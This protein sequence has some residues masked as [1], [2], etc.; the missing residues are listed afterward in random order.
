MIGILVG[1]PILGALSDKIGRKRA[2]LIS[3]IIFILAG[4]FVALAPNFTL[5]MIARFILGASSPGIY[6]TSF[7]LGMEYRTT[8]IQAFK[9]VL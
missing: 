2:I 9:R 3:S 5:L 1:S 6:A 7:V 4:P 8:R